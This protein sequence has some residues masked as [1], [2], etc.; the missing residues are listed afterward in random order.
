M[1][2]LLV[3]GCVASLMGAALIESGKTETRVEQ[4]GVPKPMLFVSRD[5]G[6][7]CN[8]LRAS[9]SKRLEFEEYDVFDGGVGAA[10]YAQYG[11]NGELPY[12][13]IGE[14]RIAGNYPGEMISAIAIEYGASQLVDD[15]RDALRRNF[16][17]KGKA[18][19]VMYANSWCGYCD[20]AR[21]YFRSRDIALVEFDIELD[22]EA[23]RDFDILR[24]RGTPLLYQGYR[25]VDGFDVQKIERDFDID[26]R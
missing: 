5:C 3:G 20:Q 26:V 16:D 2:K 6:S 1:D 17:L 9:L 12:V 10:L 22:T 4:G 23:R 25:R 24:G 13:V 8:Q 7:Q 18:R 15:E 21:D 19:V 11:G 14:Q